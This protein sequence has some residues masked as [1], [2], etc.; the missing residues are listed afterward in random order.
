MQLTGRLIEFLRELRIYP[1]PDSDLPPGVGGFPD[2]LP[3][4][5]TI[6]VDEIGL[7]AGVVDRL[8]EL[9]YRVKAFNSSRKAKDPQRFMNT[10]AEAFW[11][12][13]QKLQKGA[14]A[15]ARNDV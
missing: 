3:N 6:I 11:T 9:R 1:E 7:G 14:I 5:G 8:K 15:M 4:E 2:G 12:L 13:R 10:R